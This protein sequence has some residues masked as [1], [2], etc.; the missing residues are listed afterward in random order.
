MEY[1]ILVNGRPKK[2]S[3]HTYKFN[4]GNVKDIRLSISE[5]K[6]SVELQMKT[7]KRRMR[8]LPRGTTVS[9]RH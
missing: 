5:G 9:P 6:L 7:K 4:Y 2:D 3:C 1:K 8:Y